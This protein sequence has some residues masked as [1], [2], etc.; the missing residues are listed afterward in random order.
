MARLPLVSREWNKS[1]PLEESKTQDLKVTLLE[2]G[3]IYAMRTKEFVI[4]ETRFCQPSKPVIVAHNPIEIDT[5]A[6][7]EFCRILHAQKTDG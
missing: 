4:T 5:Q 7:L 3:S 1:Q 6:D 2:T